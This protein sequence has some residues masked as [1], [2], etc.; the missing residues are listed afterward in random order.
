MRT[1]QWSLDLLRGIFTGSVSAMGLEG[2]WQKVEE[3]GDVEV[4]MRVWA[5]ISRS[6]AWKEKRMQ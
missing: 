5:T 2:R 3:L 6:L 1:R 4:E